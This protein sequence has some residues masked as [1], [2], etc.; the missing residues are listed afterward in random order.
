MTSLA[1][2]YPYYLTNKAV[3]ANT[4]LK[5]SD[6]YSGEIAT[7]VAR[8]DATAIDAGIAAAV[9]AATVVHQLAGCWLESESYIGQEQSCAGA[10]RQ[11]D[12]YR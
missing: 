7:R 9:E 3:F 10:W 12:G 11:C 4:D 5:V 6:K 2:S 1:A 8:A